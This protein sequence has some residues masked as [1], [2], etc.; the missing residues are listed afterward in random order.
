LKDGLLKHLSIFL[1]E[2]IKAANADGKLNIVKRFLK[3][4]QDEN[5]SIIS[6]NWDLLIEV[7][8]QELDIKI[9]Y[10]KQDV[11]GGIFVSKPHGSLNL[12]EVQKKYMNNPAINIHSLDTEWEYDCGNK[13]IVRAQNPS[14]APNRIIYPSKSAL[15]IEP[16]AKKSYLSP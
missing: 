10:Q 13:V 9:N 2:K 16:T 1:C 11:N 3:K 7:G 5:A 6:F 14:D 12:R 4:V 8:A 15:I